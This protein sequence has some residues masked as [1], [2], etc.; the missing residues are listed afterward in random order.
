MQVN[1]DLVDIN[2]CPHSLIC[3]LGKTHLSSLIVDK[4]KKTPSKCLFAFLSY[5]HQQTLSA[6]SLLHSLI[7][8]LVTEDET[9][10]AVLCKSFHSN[11]G[12]L[13]G[14][15]KTAKDLLSELLLCAGPTY[16]IVDGL[17]EVE[18]GE[19]Q[20][21]L[22]ALLKVLNRCSQMKLCISSRPEHD[23]SRALK[24]SAEV[25]R[26]NHNNSGCIQAYVTKRTNEWLD[27]QEGLE[28]NARSEI[29]GILAPLSAKANG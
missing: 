19:R 7:I 24:M 12:E 29:Q 26:V 17:D 2:I 25:I 5:K 21:I 9:L 3:L 6:I 13:K 27:Q 10:Q 16:L 18:E 11:R 1:Q 15:T 14:N 20:I 4:I 28:D 23:I 8:Q 22:D